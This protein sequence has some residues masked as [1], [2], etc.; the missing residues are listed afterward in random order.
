MATGKRSADDQAIDKIEDV[1]SDI[2]GFGF[3]CAHIADFF[4]QM[5]A[6]PREAGRRRV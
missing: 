6:A 4:R 1:G 3:V 2:I 5:R